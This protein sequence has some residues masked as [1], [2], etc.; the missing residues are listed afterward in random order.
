MT[1]EGA[2]GA[3]AD[4]RTPEALL[5]RQTLYPTELRAH[6]ATSI[7]FK[8]LQ[9]TEPL[10]FRSFSVHSVQNYNLASKPEPICCVLERNFGVESRN[11][12]LLSLPI[13]CGTLGPLSASRRCP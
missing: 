5:R 13:H 10:P 3:P 8:H 9:P 12:S 1:R 7:T 6:G 2:S 11:P 4:T